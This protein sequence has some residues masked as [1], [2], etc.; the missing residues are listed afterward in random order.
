MHETVLS[1]FFLGRNDAG[2]L[3]RDLVDAVKQTSADVFT[4][5]VTPAEGTF[6]VKIEHLVRACDAVIQGDLHAHDLEKIG[7]CLVASDY[8]HWDSD[9]TEGERV[10][11][12]VYDWSAPEVNYALTSETVQK[13]KERLLTG[14]SS[15][16]Q[17][18]FH[19]GDGKGTRRSP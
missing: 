11:E 15:F 5:Y 1:D 18:D 7:F 2:A 12:T 19:K 13:F 9:T 14:K 8:F 3:Q 17:A 6:E 16:T 10:A 4:Q